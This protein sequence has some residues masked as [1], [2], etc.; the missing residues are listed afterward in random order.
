MRISPVLFFIASISG[1]SS[2]SAAQSSKLELEAGLGYAKV[3][4][5]GGLSLSAALDRPLSAAVDPV[6]HA[7]GVS[8][9]YAHTKLASQPEEP[10][11]RDVLG[12]GVRYR[13]GWQRCCGALHP[14]VAV[15]LQVLRSSVEDVPGLEANVAAHQ[16]PEPPMETQSENFTGSAW[17]WGAG[18]ELG[19]EVGLADG[20]NGETRVQ[21]LYHDIYDG[22]TSNTAWTWHTGIS[23]RF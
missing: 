12:L 3:F 20:L 15:P 9:W 10:P 17:G 11:R 4:D 13:L 1:L 7:V 8:F 5:G 2:I 21:G 6:H 16:I 19:L 14:F 23:Y 22:A 18:L